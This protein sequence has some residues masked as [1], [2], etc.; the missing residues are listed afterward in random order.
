MLEPAGLR[1]VLRALTGVVATV[2]VGASPAHAAS[3]EAAL[4]SRA[5]ANAAAAAS[6]AEIEKVSDDT[7]KMAAEYRALLKE[8][9]A[10]EVYNKQVE[11]LLDSQE[12]EMES[13]RGQ[14]EGV[15]H[16][17]R[18]IMPL[19]SRMIDGLEQFVALDV[20]FLPEERRQRVVDL[21]E[22]MGRADVTISEK[23][24]RL[25]EAYQI[26]NEFGRTIEAYRGNLDANGGKRTVDYLRIGR[27][28]LLYQTLDGE[29]TGAWD[30]KAATW[31]VLPSEY[32]ASVRE[33][34]RIARKQV[35][36]NMLY[37]PVAAAQ[38]AK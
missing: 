25:L 38:E 11:A 35:A 10:L 30:A 29:E 21:R 2:F 17:G 26:E 4:D 36:P 16:I 5:A 22:L 6:Q 14:V 7:D 12:K 32:R 19:M 3:V 18:E 24:R 37:I 1:A 31:M 15:T 34:L 9:R 8:T 27:V 20:P 13:L 23:Y 33:G 28:G